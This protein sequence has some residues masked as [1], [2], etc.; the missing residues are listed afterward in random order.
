MNAEEYGF[1]SVIKVANV[2]FQMFNLSVK[3]EDEA[4]SLTIIIFRQNYYLWFIYA[5]NTI[6]IRVATFFLFQ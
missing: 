2:Q 6:Y 3:K 1:S 5:Y 4:V